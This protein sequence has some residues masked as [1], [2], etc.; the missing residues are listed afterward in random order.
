MKLNKAL[1]VLIA[2]TLGC[3]AITEVVPHEGAS[4]SVLVSTQ[5]ASS[6][7]A[8][9]EIAFA[10]DRDGDW[11]L[12][13][14][15]S[16]GDNVVQ[17]TD[18]PSTEV[19]AAWSPDGTRIAFVSDC[20]GDQEIFVMELTALPITDVCG[21][22]DNLTNNPANDRGP[23]W[24]PDGE[25]IAFRST[26][27]GNDE[28]YVMDSDGTNQ[29]N[30][31]RDPS[32]DGEP[33]W[34]PDGTQIVF[35]SW[36]VGGT[37]VWVMDEDGSNPTRLTHGA[38]AGGPDWSPDSRWIVYITFRPLYLI[39]LDAPGPVGLGERL[40]PITDG[41]ELLC[42]LGKCSAPAWSPDG[43]QIALT[44][45]LGF[46]GPGF[47]TN[48]E[49][50]IT[51]RD[52]TGVR[53]LTDNTALDAWPDWRWA[54]VVQFGNHQPQLDGQVEQEINVFA[55]LSVSG[56][57]RYLESRGED[58]DPMFARIRRKLLRSHVYPISHQVD[59]E[60]SSAVD[61]ENVRVFI[62]D[63]K[64]NVFE[65]DRTFLIRRSPTGGSVVFQKYWFNEHVT[66]R[67]V[68]PL[69]SGYTATDVWSFEVRTRWIKATTKAT[70]KGLILGLLG[71]FRWIADAI[72]ALLQP[73]PVY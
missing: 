25:R 55:L 44:V 29:R 72:V 27:D 54:P 6:W 17:L 45:D 69:Q 47:G 16:N 31:T 56:A 73:T 19:K 8:V 67:T 5:T 33:D 20:S 30:L 2:G 10:S 11:D 63:D 23:A 9:P 60:A 58:G 68:V 64:N 38:W 59:F 50:Y 7:L 15:D 70:G 13:A 18:A 35:T 28:V 61:F 52:G 21:R 62:N 26:R 36:R 12:Y 57:V 48:A 4:H 40:D 51:N 39:D 43:T 24:S 71:P 66:V 42:V 65:L 14:M 3:E 41:G 34:S 53:R 46:H 37:E 1:G 22:L 32:R 49:I